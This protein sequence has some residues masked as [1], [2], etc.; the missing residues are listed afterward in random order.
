MVAQE[1]RRSI[2][3]TSIP[4]ALVQVMSVAKQVKA[5]VTSRERSMHLQYL[6]EVVLAAVIE[7]DVK[8]ILKAIGHLQVA[9]LVLEAEQLQ[10]TWHA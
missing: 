2:D 1:W 3:I 5:M 4:T 9:C 10:K 7:I 6:C 8:G